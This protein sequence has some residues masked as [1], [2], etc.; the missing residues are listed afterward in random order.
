MGSFHNQTSSTCELCPIGF[1]NDQERQT[2]CI[3]CPLGQTTQDPGA[4][5]ISQCYCKYQGLPV[6][7][8]NQLFNWFSMFGS[9]LDM[10]YVI[11]VSKFLNQ[12]VLYFAGDYFMINIIAL[13]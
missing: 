11:T 1:Y 9:S 8:W 7:L 12:A 5:Y 2:N 6:N 13:I 10:R 4:K 3:L